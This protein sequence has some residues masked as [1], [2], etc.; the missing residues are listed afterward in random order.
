MVQS[1]NASDLHVLKMQDKHHIAEAPPFDIAD[2]VGA[3]AMHIACR[4]GNLDMCVLNQ[5]PLPRTFGACARVCTMHVVCACNGYVFASCFCALFVV[6]VSDVC[7]QVY[8][9]APSVTNEQRALVRRVQWLVELGLALDSKAHNGATPAHD[10]AATGHLTCL[11]CLF[12]H[13]PSL[14]DCTLLRNALLPIH[15]AALYGQTEVLRWLLEDLASDPVDIA[16]DGSTCLHYAAARGHVNTIK[17]LASKLTPDQIS[18]KNTKGV[19]A[20]TKAC[21]VNCLEG[22]KVL[23]D[24]GA[25]KASAADEVAGVAH[26]AHAAARS[27]ALATLKFLIDSDP[28]L[29]TLKDVDGATPAHFAA[30]AGQEGTLRYLLTEIT[31]LPEATKELCWRDNNGSTPIHD[32]AFNGKIGSLR[33]LADTGVDLSLQV[34]VHSSALP[35]DS[36]CAR[37]C[38]YCVVYYLSSSDCGVVKLLHFNFVN[39]LSAALYFVGACLP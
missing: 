18:I 17:Y 10:A 6:L 11:Q 20:L 1:K 31:K 2:Q 35:L 8:V 7:V 16:T 26:L 19:A 12:F 3:N 37:A 15:M 23:L 28:G 13:K 36:V 30:A 38:V 29:L 27:G 33:V 32:A 25:E 22:V 5:Q 34:R 9:P 4:V 21:E 14:K 39:S 24:A